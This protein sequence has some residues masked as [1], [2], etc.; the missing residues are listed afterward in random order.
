MSERLIKVAS[1]GSQVEAE[2]VVS[3]LR[4]REIAAFVEG[5]TVNTTLSAVAS[6]LGGVTLLI[7]EADLAAVQ[8]LLASPTSDELLRDDW[9]C[10]ECEETNDAS[11]EICWSCG[12][13]REQIEVDNPLQNKPS[14]HPAPTDRDLSNPYSPSHVD[15]RA[16]KSS[17]NARSH[18]QI[19]EDMVIRAHRAAWIGAVVLPFILHAYSVY[20]LLRV[21]TMRARMPEQANW[22]WYWALLIDVVT[23]SFWIAYY[24]L[25]WG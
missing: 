11:F 6:P 24:Q 7:S 2:H 22:L 1:Y 3:L 20:L 18:D 12:E 4:E 21:A 23:A 8:E 13:V 25:T 14:P 16:E 17:P 15:S 10:G 19:A 9:Y 5:A